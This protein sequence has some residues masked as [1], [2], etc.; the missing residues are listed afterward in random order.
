MGRLG[1]AHRAGVVG[2]NEDPFDMA[3]RETPTPVRAAHGRNSSGTAIG[4]ESLGSE[5]D[6]LAHPPPPG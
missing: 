2:G 1:S 3:A 4:L 5:P 6:A